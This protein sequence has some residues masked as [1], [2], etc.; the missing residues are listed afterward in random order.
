MTEDKFKL[1][2]WNVDNLGPRISSANQGSGQA[3]PRKPGI[4]YLKKSGLGLYS[5]LN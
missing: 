1:G 4:S 5:K 2:F 3:Y